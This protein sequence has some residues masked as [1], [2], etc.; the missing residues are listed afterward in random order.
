V[1]SEI[2]TQVM[3][4]GFDDLDAPVRRLNGAFI[5]A[6]YSQVFAPGL[7]PDAAGIAQSV[8]DLLAE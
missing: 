5:P 8:R 2:A 3:E 1:A 4:Q 7:V 6:P